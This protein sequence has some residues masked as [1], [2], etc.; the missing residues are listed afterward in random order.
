MT[1]LWWIIP[2]LA[3][4][5]FFCFLVLLGILTSMGPFVYSVVN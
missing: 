3:A 5:A 1:A 4:V 2:M